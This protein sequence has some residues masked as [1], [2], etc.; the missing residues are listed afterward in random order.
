M[1]KV[2]QVIRDFSIRAVGISLLELR[3]QLHYLSMAEIRYLS[4]CASFGQSP[5]VIIS[6][7]GTEQ[8]WNG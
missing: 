3:A 5:F 4:Q 6:S 8:P 1:Y 7:L 2:L